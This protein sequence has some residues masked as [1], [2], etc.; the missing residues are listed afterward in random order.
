MIYILLLF[1]LF[2]TESVHATGWV[3]G[4]DPGIGK[5]LKAP[6]RNSKARCWPQGL[7]RI[8]GWIL[9]KIMS[10]LAGSVMIAVR[11]LVIFF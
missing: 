8:P 1:T 2:T 4:G 9:N 3:K 10:F 11:F 5:G 7:M 6:D